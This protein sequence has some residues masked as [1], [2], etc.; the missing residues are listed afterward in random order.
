M[1]YTCSLRNA[2]TCI[3]AHTNTIAHAHRASSGAERGNDYLHIDLPQWLTTQNAYIISSVAINSA[4][5]PLVSVCFV[6]W[7][8]RDLVRWWHILPYSQFYTHLYVA[9]CG[10]SVRLATPH[11]NRLS[12]KCFTFT[13]E[14]PKY[15]KQLTEQFVWI[16]KTE[17]ICG[18]T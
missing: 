6:C 7:R 16:A 14:L 13:K 18:E 5:V 9:E 8:R 3:I 2:R 4:C 17:T 12:H 11:L 15:Q 1:L 10:A